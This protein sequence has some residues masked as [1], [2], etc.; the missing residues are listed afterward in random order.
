MSGVNEELI[1]SRVAGRK[2]A[3]EYVQLIRSEVDSLG[4]EGGE[5]FMTALLAELQS[6]APEPSA[7]YV[8]PQDDPAWVSAVKHC[9]EILL[10]CGAVMQDE[11]REFADSVED[12]VGGIRST[13]MRTKRVTLAQ[14]EALQNM[15]SGVLA[16]LNAT[17]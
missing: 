5:A 10:D 9:D 15:H 1:K 6:M 13:I 2:A 8:E 14:S 17:D 3:E 12:M 7:R 11:G 16:W 4:S